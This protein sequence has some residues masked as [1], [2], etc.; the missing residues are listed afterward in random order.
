VL[1]RLTTYKREPGHTEMIDDDGCTVVVMTRIMERVSVTHHF[2]MLFRFFP[3][4]R[5]QERYL[6][7][8][9]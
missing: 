2:M 5:V 4:L 8:T 3:L 7:S 1:S 6:R 9:R